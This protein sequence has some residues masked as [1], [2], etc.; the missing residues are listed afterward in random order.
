MALVIEPGH[1]VVRLRRKFGAR[2]PPAC[3]RLEHRKTA[4]AQQDVQQRGDEHGFRG[5][6]QTGNAKPYSGMCSR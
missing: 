3:K 6:R 1:R 5:A 4:A 2:D